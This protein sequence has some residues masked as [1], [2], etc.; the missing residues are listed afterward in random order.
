MLGPTLFLVY[1]NDLPDSIVSKLVMYADDTTIFDSIEKSSSAA[2]RTHLCNTL[3][4]DLQTIEDWGKRWLVS[5]NPSKTNSLLHSRLRDRSQHPSLVMSGTAMEEQEAI[6]LLGLTV[7]S[8]LSWK[9]YLQSI[10]K[11]ASQR[12]GCLYRASRFLHPET[13]LYLYKSTVR[14]IMEYCCHLWAG[15]PRTHLYPLDRVER[16][17]KNLVGQDASEK[18]EPLSVRRDVAS[19]SLFYRYYYGQCS[20]SLSDCIPQAKVF[21]RTTRA[22]T[23]STMLQVQVE[24]S[25]TVGRS[26]SF[27]VRTSQI[28]NELPDSVFPDRYDLTTFKSRVNRFRRDC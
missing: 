16:R 24:S 9:P 22:A 17:V 4:R 11:Q 18:L 20:S 1:I 15:A 8:D 27:F 6:S 21:T 14:P 23:S 26:R 3:N 7:R 5:F 25:R 12:V 10:C 13:I 28:W 19:L 2:Q